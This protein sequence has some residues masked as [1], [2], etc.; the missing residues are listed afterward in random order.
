MRWRWGPLFERWV[1]MMGLGL[2]SAWIAISLPPAEIHSV[3]KAELRLPP[4]L[5]ESRLPLC[6][7][8]P[9]QKRGC[10]AALRYLEEISSPNRAPAS[11][12][13]LEPAQRFAQLKKTVQ[14]GH[15]DWVS[16]AFN[17]WLLAID[18]HAKLVSAEDADRRA[19]ADKIFVQGAGAKL[20]FH[21]GKVFVGYVMEGSAAEAAGLKPGDRVLALNGKN[22]AELNETARRRW[23]NQTQSPYSLRIERKG[24]EIP[25]KI[26]EKRYYLA[27][28]EGKVRVLANGKREGVLRVRSFD[29]DHTCGDLGRALQA[30]Q[31]EGVTQLHLDLRDNPGGLVREAQCAAAL[32]LGKGKAFA[33]LKRKENPE[34]ERFIPAVPASGGYVQEEVALKTELEARTQL[35]LTVE[36]NQ[37]SASAAEMLAA[38]LQDNRRAKVVGVRSFGK[39]S[40]QSVFHPW[41][42][43]KLYLTRTTHLIFRP[44]GKTLQF[45][46]VT[47]DKISLVREGENFPRERELT[48]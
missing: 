1:A 25:M 21:Q 29:K 15:G 32:F 3:E 13:L 9:V 47:P 39:G 17:A 16:G 41:S 8:T 45:E 34:T 12:A 2:L 5:L 43:E 30:V 28:V 6:R 20:R 46:G 31:K 24:R 37:N 44:S 42:D 35:P 48:L 27:N 38:A 19:S 23:L 22:L 26:T 33:Q 18:P 11:Q 7:K 40:M 10:E 4:P 14:A 36:I